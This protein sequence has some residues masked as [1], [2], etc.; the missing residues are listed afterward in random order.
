MKNEKFKI[1]LFLNLIKYQLISLNYQFNKSN[2]Q[3][4]TNFL[5]QW[6]QNVM[7]Q[8]QVHLKYKQN[9]SISKA[10]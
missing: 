9:F 8:F 1:K 3:I 2:K 4:Y 6:I 7:V 10:Q 5:I